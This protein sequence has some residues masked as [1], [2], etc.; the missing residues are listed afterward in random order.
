MPTHLGTFLTA[1]HA[2]F[3]DHVP[4]PPSFGTATL[5]RPPTRNL[6]YLAT[7]QVLLGAPLRTSPPAAALKRLRHWSR[8]QEIPG[9]L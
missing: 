6:R 8:R 4:L 3:S 2:S 5:G 7:V 1:P 9:R